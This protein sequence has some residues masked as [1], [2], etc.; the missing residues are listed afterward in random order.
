MA[1]C[2]N[3]A[4]GSIPQTSTKDRTCSNKNLCGRDGRMICGP[5]CVPKCRK[6]RMPSVRAEKYIRDAS[7]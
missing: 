6:V 5:Q 7:G 2:M 3:A 4:Q 1:A